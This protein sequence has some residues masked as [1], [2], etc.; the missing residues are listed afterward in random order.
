MTRRGC[1]SVKAQ[2]IAVF[3]ELHALHASRNRIAQRTKFSVTYVAE[4]L[5]DLGLTERWD[6]DADWDRE[7]AIRYP[8]LAEACERLAAINTLP[9][10]T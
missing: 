8:A 5:R 10:S 6:Q 9:S 2:A 3:T 1:H 4:V 7:L